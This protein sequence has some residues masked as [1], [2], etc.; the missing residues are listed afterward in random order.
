MYLN[1]VTE[2]PSEL[3]APNSPSQKKGSEPIEFGDS[4]FQRDATS[5]CVPQLVEARAIVLPDVLAVS[6]GARR[7][8]YAALDRRSN[9]LARHLQ[10]L[11]VLPGSVVG[12]CLERSVDFPVAAMAIWKTGCA[13]LPLEMKTPIERLRLMLEKAGASVVLTNSGILDSLTG[14]TR[15]LVALDRFAGEINRCSPERLVF[16]ASL[17]DPA[18]VIFTSGSTG[19]PKAVQVG[20]SSLLNLV[21]WHNRAF[22]VTAED[23]ATQLASIG[24]DA[25]V[26][27]LWP[28]LVAG[29]SVHVVDEETRPQAEKL[30]DWLVREQ[31]TISFVPTPVAEQM[32]KLAWPVQTRL[33]VLLTGAD[34]LHQY[35]G[36]N[37][38]FR[39]VNNYGPTECTVVATSATLE[40]GKV[41][42]RPP[43]G[44]PIDNV[45]V[46][47][48]D[49]D[50]RRVPAGQTGEIFVGGECLALGYLN[51]PALTAERFV[52]HPFSAKNDARLYRTGDLG[53]FRADGSIE[54]HGRADDQVKIRGYRIE[55]NDVIGALLRH[56]AI[57]EGTVVAAADERGE[58]RLVAYIVARETTPT[59]GELRNFLGDIL[60]DYMVPAAFVALE[61]LPIGSN[62][63]V[64]RALLPAVCDENI[65]RDETQIGPRT[66]TERRIA[67]IVGSLLG[68]KSVGVND[69]FFFLGGNSLFGTQVIARLREAFNVEVSLLALFDHPTVTATAA[70]VERLMVAKLD[71][72]SDEEVQRLLDSNPEPVDL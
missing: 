39:L 11:G 47:I 36:A 21:K 42:G 65:L 60:P 56:Q 14:G 3:S 24:F 46:Y 29:A 55:L 57:R 59:V 71:S 31:I 63:K 34:V 48:L 72:M 43:I 9:Q 22:E 44:K 52:Q 20:H 62:G 30:R 68:L 61:N 15:Q 54:F 38:P 28:Y 23:R 45:E 51:D 7:L 69:N 10:G 32:V 16:P 13:Y 4:Y 27:E 35:P 18:Y 17:K 64:D 25:A 66:P 41:G 33:R 5:V 12:V 19:A 40:M 1:R 67:G 53:R 58:K 49:A 70:E 2:V 6:C 8:S 50:M 37:L 26:W